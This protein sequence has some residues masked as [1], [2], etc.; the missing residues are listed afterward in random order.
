[1]VH[2]LRFVNDKHGNPHFLLMEKNFK[3][4]AI[5]KDTKRDKCGRLTWCLREGGDDEPTVSG[6]KQG[7]ATV[8]KV[9]AFLKAKKIEN[10]KCVLSIIKLVLPL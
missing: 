7:V 8:E 2:Q 1:M 10:G 6:V 3:F 4:V 9:E 5:R